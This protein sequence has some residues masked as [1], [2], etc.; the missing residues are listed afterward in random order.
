MFT[1]RHRPWVALLC[2]LGLVG[3]FA[4]WAHWHRAGTVGYAALERFPAE[5]DGEVVAIS[6]ARVARIDGPDR[7]V[8][9]KGTQGFDVHGPSAGLAVGDDV[10][11]GGVFH[12]D[13]PAIE[14]TWLENRQA[15]RRAKRWLGGFGLLGAVGL[16]LGSVRRE[17][18]EWRLRG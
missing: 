6:L 5:H 10:S 14:L 16:W 12:A 11:L 17:G 2:V 9:E 8:L 7:F 15:G 18:W 1:D 4:T 13:G 3:C